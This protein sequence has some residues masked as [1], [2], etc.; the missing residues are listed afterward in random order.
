MTHGI[1]LS[2]TAVDPAEYR[3]GYVQCAAEFRRKMTSPVPET[4]EQ[5]E[6][7][8]L[9]H[10]AS[11]CQGNSPNNTVAAVPVF[12]TESLRYM[13]PLQPVMIPFPSPPPS[14]LHVSP[15][16]AVSTSLTRDT[17]PVPP[18]SISM[19]RHTRFISS[20]EPKLETPVQGAS[21]WRPW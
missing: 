2:F 16:L 1:S 18:A 10:L 13:A 12:G 3:A 19:T 9:A 15:V 14:P 8:F 4:K 20:Q 11:R 17:A 6:A 5:V 21:L 7:N